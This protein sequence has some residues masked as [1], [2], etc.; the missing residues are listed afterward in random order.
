M[1][2]TQLRRKIDG[3]IYFCEAI[4]ETKEGAINSRNAQKFAG[5]FA[6]IIPVSEKGIKKYGVYVAFH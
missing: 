2:D 6:R 1:S 5:F 4:R 3:K